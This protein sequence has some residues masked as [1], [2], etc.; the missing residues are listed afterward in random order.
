MTNKEIAGAFRELGQL[1]EL[2]EDNPFKIRS[3]Q[4]AYMRLRKLDRPLAEMEPAERESIP[5]VGKAIAGKIAELLDAGHMAALEKLRDKT[6][7]GVVEMLG[8]SG[9]G[10]KKVR[11]VWRD[12]GAETIGELHYAVNENRLVELKGFGQ[13]TQEDLKLKLNY[14][15]RSR[16]QFHYA[17]LEAP[18]AELSQLLQEQLPEIRLEPTGA[19]RRRCNTLE[20]IELLAAR[21]LTAVAVAKVAGCSEVVASEPDRLSGKFNDF[22]FTIWLSPAAA[23]GSRLFETTGAKGFLEAYHGAFPEVDTTG[24][25]EEADVFARA[26]IPVVPAELREGDW[27]LD[28]ARRGSLPELISRADIRGVVHSHTTYSDGIHS[29]ARMAAYAKE[30]GYEYLAISDHSKVAVYANGLSIERVHAQWAEIDTLNRQDPDFR[31]LKSIEC[32]IL[33]D[34]SLD[35]PDEVLAGFDFV[36][37]SIHSNLR[38]DES[39]AT[40]RL[41]RAIENPHTHMLGHPTGRLLLSRPGYPIDHLRVIDAC[42]EHRVCIELNANPYRLDLDWSWIPYARERG[43]PISINP[44]AHSTG[45]IDDIHYGVLAARKGGLT[46]RGCLNALPVDEFRAWLRR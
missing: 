33:A 29:V 35:Y 12:L 6:P 8:I 42:A 30:Q 38:M 28:R 10:P 45:G 3:Y 19:L 31:I 7:P 5:G 22:P 43:V 17:A 34:G 40:E 14:F 32:D 27:A 20:R 2:H 24:L 4:N 18:A 23:F 21:P 26:G 16:N 36:I 41:L 37:A 39:K 9:F 44:D 46:K 25:A 1:M 11:T 13:K 15:L